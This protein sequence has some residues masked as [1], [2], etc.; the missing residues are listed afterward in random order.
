MKKRGR[1]A[2]ALL[3]FLTVC[4]SGCATYD[5][6]YRTFLEQGEESYETVKIGIFE[7]LSGSDKKFGEL[8]KIGIELAHEL[9]PT[10]MGKNVELIYA[11][12]K[13]DI[14]VAEEAIQELLSENPAIILGSYGSVYSLIAGKYI[15]EAEVPAISITNTNPLVTSNNSFY[16]R[17]GFVDSYQGIALA[18]YAF[19]SLG[20]TQAAILK[21]QNDDVASALCSAFED[22][23]VQLTGNSSAIAITLE[24]AAG[25]TD[26]TA[27]L[28]SIKNAGLSTVFLP[29]AADDGAA[30][31]RAAEKMGLHAVFLGTE[32]WD[33]ESFLEAAGDAANM[34]VFSTI[35]D[36][37]TSVNSQA[38]E[39]LS[40]YRE[41]YGIDAVPEPEVALGFDAYMIAVEA[42]NRIGT[43]KDG[44]LLR[45]SLLLT[46]QYPGA[47][48]NITFD[49]NGDP[50]KSVV[51]KGIRNGES[52]NIYTMEPNLV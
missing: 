22:K 24:Y 52:Q 18:K 30:I 6:F 2:A 40:A 39:F 50:M 13:S 28:E 17:V 15:E 20:T 48:G 27:Q 29:A 45:R 3:V 32:A 26:F 12:N 37:D 19:E 10:C 7:P 21:P 25:D 44:D 46:S 31:L 1:I 36:A 43:V 5:A 8:E 33:T 35:Y 11:D 41:K 14:Y 9:Q 38:E 4:L 47:S 16:F 51:I 23:L 34:A 42:L 49:S